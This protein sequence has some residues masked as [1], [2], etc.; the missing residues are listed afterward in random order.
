M[1]KI[2]IG[3]LKKELKQL[4]QEFEHVMK[5]GNVEIMTHRFNAFL[6]T[7]HQYGIDY[8]MAMNDENLRDELIQN[9]NFLQEYSFM[10]DASNA[11]WQNWILQRP[12]IQ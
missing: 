5:S 11:I 4:K 10:L 8:S 2:S 3:K 12:I 1:K 9:R 7:V 6:D